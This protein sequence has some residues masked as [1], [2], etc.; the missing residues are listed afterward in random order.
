[1]SL[2]AILEAIRQSGADRVREIEVRAREE[3]ARIMAEAEREAA[4]TQQQARH[5]ASLTTAADHARIVH[6][7]RLEAMQI[8]GEAEQQIVEQ[9]LTQVKAHLAGLRASADYPDLLRHLLVDALAALQGS[10]LEDEPVHLYADPRDRTLLETMLRDLRLEPVVLYELETWGGVRATNPE[11]RITV[12]NTLESRLALATPMLKR[13]L[14]ALLRQ[15]AEDSPA[16]RPVN[17]RSSTL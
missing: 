12:D 17:R 8:V 3:V 11:D 16:L 5:T 6:R 10:L 14:P 1:M 4:A 15:D 13:H 9:A 7:A 2:E